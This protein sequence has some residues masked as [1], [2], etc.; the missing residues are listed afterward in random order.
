M[1]TLEKLHLTQELTQ[2]HKL[3]LRQKIEILK[4]TNQTIQTGLLV[5][6][7]VQ[8]AIPE[9]NTITAGHTHVQAVHLHQQTEIPTVGQ[10]TTLIP[11]TVETITL[12]DPAQITHIDLQE[13][14]PEVLE[15]IIDH[16]TILQTEVQEAAT[17][18]QEVLQT[19]VQEATEVHLHQDQA[20]VQAIVVPEVLQA[21]VQEAVTDLQEAQAEVVVQEAA[22]DLLEVHLTH[23]EA[24]QDL[25][26][27][28]QAAHVAQVVADNLLN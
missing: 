7:N 13:V 28:V 14:Q 27:A 4:R 23:P 12:L 17:D 9:I 11:T 2:D 24:A 18:L 8:K 5:I 1:T 15:A 16:P 19:E 6:T 26:Q 10:I 20:L 22:T 3:I 25:V 21:I